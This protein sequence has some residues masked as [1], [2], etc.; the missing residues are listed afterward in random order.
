[1]KQILPILLIL[2]GFFGTARAQPAQD[3]LGNFTFTY[4]VN[5]V[6]LPTPTGPYGFIQF[7]DTTAGK[8][9]SIT[10]LASSSSQTQQPFTLI[11]ATVSSP[12]FS[13]LSTQTAIPVGGAGSLRITFSPTA[14]NP[15]QTT[16]T[17]QF[18]LVSA[19]GQT[20][21]VYITIF[22]NV[23][24]P[25]LILTYIDPTS[26]N[27]VPLS[28]GGILQFPKT[29][30]KASSVAQI[31]VLNKGTGS[32]IVDSVSVTGTG[33]T[34]TNEP[35]TP[36]AIAAGSAFTVGVTFSPLAI[37]EYKGTAVVSVGGVS[38]T[39]NLDGQGTNSAFSYSLLSIVGNG[40]LLPNGI[41]T[42]PD[43]PADGVSKS[44]VTL[45]VQNTGNQNGP[46][47]SILVLGSDFQ[48]TNTPV[49]PEV[50]APGDI[51]VFNVVF[52]PAKAG[53][54]VGRLQI[55]SDL[56][57]LTGNALGS[58]LSLAVDVGLGPTAVANKAV[59]TLPSTTV[60][61]KR[62]VYI[63]VTNTGNQPAI[64]NG[65]GVSGTGFTIPTLTGP[66]TL[67]PSQTIQFQVQFAP[68]TVSS[69]TGIVNINDQTLT[70]LGSGQAPP[71]LP[72]VSF[73]NVASVLGPLQQPAAGLQFSA[74]YPYDVRGVLTLS[75]ISD[76]FVDDP[77]IQF[78][79]GKRAINF[80]IPAN[81][82]Q[83]IFLQ[84]SG[85]SIG[86][87]A[88]FQTGTVS[89]LVSLTVSGLT[90]GQVDL[91]PG[92]PAAKSYQIP[93]T[94]PQLRSIQVRSFIGNQIV[95]VISGYSTPRN[96][97]QLSFQFTGASGSNLTTSSLNLDV[98]GAFTSW[99]TSA[100]SDVFGSQFAVS[101]TATITGDPTALQ[102]ISVTATNSKGTSA[103]QT[104]ALR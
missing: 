47:S 57:N 45:Q 63:N 20:F 1:L 9:T 36:A 4:F 18:Q 85:S 22:A 66:A 12:G 103:A 39:I 31:V 7:P 90:V 8:S 64:I 76:S 54:S 72:S 82:T 68:L 30:V 37:Q 92:T 26:G 15:L 5:G 42:L 40:S 24:Q 75:F 51:A 70:L 44:S 61:D 89:G 21:N 91:T 35:L 77:A 81:T 83:A 28:Q 14:A 41:I 87:L 3:S 49:L 56:F 80:L 65:I 102:S 59:V 48:V 84:A 16:G 10:F 79:T 97:S 58:S 78:A 33:F 32:G 67:S 13:L 52:Q 96:L 29:T 71:P 104:V 62:L 69:S 93:A 34:L 11:N 98:S 86:T 100:D 88:A 46:L 74:L 2:T 17:L 55:G 50:L 101:I 19:T 99:Y 38:T 60:G 95:L 43:T 6:P 94:V 25:N 73:T 23:L 27:Q 53:T